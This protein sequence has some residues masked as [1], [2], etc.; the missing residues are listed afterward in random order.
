MSIKITGTD[1]SIDK[2]YQVSYQNVQVSLD[3]GS[4][5]KINKCR[6]LA[7]AVEVA[8]DTNTDKDLRRGDFYQFGDEIDD[9]ELKAKKMVKMK[10]A[11]RG[12]RPLVSGLV[13]Q[14]SKVRKD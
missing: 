4:I 2:L 13:K 3:K 14:F 12:K 5:A 8:L 1:L 11:I 9:E 10:E 6:K 7:K